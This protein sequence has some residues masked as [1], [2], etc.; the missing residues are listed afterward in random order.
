M[1]NR[2]G[3]RDAPRCHDGSVFRR[4][5]I[6]WILAWTAAACAPTAAA[7]CSEARSCAEQGFEAES[8]G[9]FP[10]AVDAY[11]RAI[12][13]G[14]SG[15]RAFNQRGYARFKAADIKSSI[16]DFDRAVAL[17]H[18][19]GPYHWQRGIALYYAERFEDGKS[20]FESHQG[21]NP[22][23]VENGVWHF[24]CTARLLG[25]DRARSQML[26]ISGDPR[27]PMKQIYELFRG[28]GSLEAVTAAAEAGAARPDER[29]NQ[30]FYANLY[31]GLYY[32]VVGDQTRAA[33]RMIA[34][35]DDAD[36]GHYMW[37]TARVHRELRGW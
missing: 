36:L 28:E 10:A 31:L 37:Q 7:D 9:R 33:E 20:Q 22:N 14:W 12:E 2:N 21:V 6:V 24:L 26:P 11:S 19:L 1:G 16:A 23:D 35:V 3:R 27:V 15:P 17:D 18:Q 8:A 4:T 25:V 29:A 32:E 34:A 13:L 30:L 5:D